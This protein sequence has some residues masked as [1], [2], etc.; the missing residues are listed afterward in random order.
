MDDYEYDDE[1]CPKCGHSPTHAG[2]CEVIGCDDGWIDRFDEDPLWYDDD[3]PEMCDE[4]HGTGWVRW[5]PKCGFDLQK[6]AQ[7]RTS[8]VD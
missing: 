7:N 5:C 2:R 6:H 4:C 3:S 1:P 8:N